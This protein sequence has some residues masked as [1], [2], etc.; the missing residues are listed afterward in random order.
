MA[1][2]NDKK[3]GWTALIAGEKAFHPSFPTSQQK[4]SFIAYAP[5]VLFHHRQTNTYDIIPLRYITVSS[6]W[7]SIPNIILHFFFFNATENLFE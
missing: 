4:H 5:L 1:L 7:F 6:S 2:R 3:D